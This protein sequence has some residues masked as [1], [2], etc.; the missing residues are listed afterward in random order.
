ML[1]IAAIRRAIEDVEIAAS[2]TAAD[3]FDGSPPL[4]GTLARLY[5]V[6]A[7]RVLELHGIS[8]DLEELCTQCCRQ[9]PDGRCVRDEAAG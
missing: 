7:Q 5:G 8:V 3:R 2:T 1:N 4:R 6:Y 9:C